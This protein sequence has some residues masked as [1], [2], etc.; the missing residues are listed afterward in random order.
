MKRHLAQAAACVA[1]GILYIASPTNGAD[2]PVQ[3]TAQR[4]T[5]SDSGERKPL[6]QEM[7]KGL[8]WLAKTQLQ[9]GAWGQGEESAHMGRDMS[10]IKDS[11]NVAD[12][13][14]AVMALFR[15]GN[16]PSEGEYKDNVLKGVNF[17]CSQ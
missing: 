16:T 12:T 1:V 13:C 10:K 2:K 3:P 11:P 9:N 7:K 4:R 17:V 8:A 15:A 5:I 14:M 6:T